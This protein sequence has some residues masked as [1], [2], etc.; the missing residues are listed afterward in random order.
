MHHILQILLRDQPHRK[1][2]SYV[3]TLG[4][5]NIAIILGICMAI[6]GWSFANA[7]DNHV[8][9]DQVQSGDNFSVSIDQIVSD[10]L[11]DFSFYHFRL[12]FY[13]P[14]F[15]FIKFKILFF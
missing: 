10:N 6:L 9:I 1:Y 11:V 5:V 12:P 2:D 3:E 13:F 4:W 7:G 15:S 14:L 8:H